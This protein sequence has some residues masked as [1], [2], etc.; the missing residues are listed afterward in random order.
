MKTHIRLVIGVGTAC[1]AGLTAIAADADKL[2]MRI[3]SH[4]AGG[5]WDHFREYEILDS[6]D[7]LFLNLDQQIEPPLRDNDL[8]AESHSDDLANI[9]APNS[10]GI[11]SAIGESWIPSSRPESTG[12]LVGQL[13]LY[14]GAADGM[15]RTEMPSQTHGEAE[16][17]TVW[18]PQLFHQWTGGTAMAAMPW[19][20]IGSIAFLVVLLARMFGSRRSRDRHLPSRKPAVTTPPR[21]RE[22]APAKT[23]PVTKAVSS[24]PTGKTEELEEWSLESTHG[25]D[26]Q[27]SRDKSEERRQLESWRKLSQVASKAYILREEEE[28]AKQHAMW[29]SLVAIGLGVSGLGIIA[30]ASL[31]PYSLLSG[32]CLAVMSLVMLSWGGLKV[33]F[34]QLRR[35]ILLRPVRS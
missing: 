27:A 22:S 4:L 30:T 3:N 33:V 26:D 14:A 28:T 13:P 8:E 16:L 25:T 20:L 6:V 15:H 12:C 7:R 24:I 9:V 17:V 18:L 19:A 34:H 2:P 32:V 5:D 31:G 10:G 35:W 1:L 11:R 23:L 29:L 21:P